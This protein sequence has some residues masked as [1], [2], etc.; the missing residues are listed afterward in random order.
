MAR[1]LRRSSNGVRWSRASARTLRLN[2]IH[3]RSRSR[4]T[5]FVR[6]EGCLRFSSRLFTAKLHVTSAQG[7]TEPRGGDPRRKVRESYQHSSRFVAPVFPAPRR[8]RVRVQPCWIASNLRD[9]GRPE[10]APEPRY[11]LATTRGARTAGFKL[12]ENEN[13]VEAGCWIGASTTRPSLPFFNE[14][15]STIHHSTTRPAAPEKCADEGPD[16]LPNGA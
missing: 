6:F 12:L 11:A 3:E 15:G 13:R 2:S 10:R 7:L 4:C 1:N 5:A 14:S 9:Q 16:A 8:C